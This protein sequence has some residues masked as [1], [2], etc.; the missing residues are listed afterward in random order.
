MKNGDG[1][2]QSAEAPAKVNLRPGTYKLVFTSKIDSEAERQ[3]DISAEVT[4]KL[5]E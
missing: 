5:T 4:L 2:D 1:K 3:D